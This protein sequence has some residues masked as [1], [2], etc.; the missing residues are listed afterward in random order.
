MTKVS[1]VIEVKPEFTPHFRQNRRR[2]LL[3]QV[4]K[5]L[6]VV[7]RYDVDGHYYYSN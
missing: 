2:R 6:R 7:N 4:S 1:V 5:Q 3:L